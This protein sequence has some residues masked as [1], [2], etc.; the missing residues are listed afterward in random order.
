MKIKENYI[1]E[2][3]K[4]A[5]NILNKIAETGTIK[6]EQ[7]DF[8][9]MFKNELNSYYKISPIQK[10]INAGKQIITFLNGSENLEVNKDDKL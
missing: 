9:I 8:L 2:M 4:T 5:N 1:A 6:Q 10:I 3:Q 7:V